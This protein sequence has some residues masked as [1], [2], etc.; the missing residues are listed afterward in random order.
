MKS[1][2]LNLSLGL[3]VYVAAFVFSFTLLLFSCKKDVNPSSAPVSDEEAKTVSQESANDDDD[4]EYLTEIGFSASADIDVSAGGEIP[5][6]ANGA[7]LGADL[8]VFDN[9][10]FKIGPCTTITVT[11]NDTTYPKI[12]VIDYHD[13]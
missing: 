2:K 12:V 13:G 4:Y 9:L 11:P 7:G 1:G 8:R 10:A 3:P 6:T 5:G